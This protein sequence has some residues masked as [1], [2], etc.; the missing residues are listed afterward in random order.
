MTV[1]CFD[2]LG[3]VDKLNAMDNTGG[4]GVSSLT[5]AAT[6]AQPIVSMTVNAAS[7]QPIITAT[8]LTTLTYAALDVA[9]NRRGYEEPEHRCRDRG[10]WLRFR[11]RGPQSILRRA[12]ARHARRHGYSDRQR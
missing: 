5:Y 10:R 7:A 1:Q 11:L 8:G 4:S 9:G 3:L 2:T 6:G 12:A